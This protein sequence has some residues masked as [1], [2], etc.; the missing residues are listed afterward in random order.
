MIK[1]KTL[2]NGR[3]P[4]WFIGR[5]PDQNATLV[6]GTMKNNRAESTEKHLQ[7]TEKQQRD[8]TPGSGFFPYEPPIPGHSAGVAR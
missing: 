1:D 4:D 8:R 2:T 3:E 5:I 7:P 6:P